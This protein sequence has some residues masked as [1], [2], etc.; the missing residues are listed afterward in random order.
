M[1]ATSNPAQ[2][3]ERH[4]SPRELAELWHLSA[5]HIRAL[6]LREP[7]VLIT[8]SRKYRTMRIPE[9]VAVRVHARSNSVSPAKPIR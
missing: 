6:F 5:D 8:G 4:F 9:S 2:V 7:G 3:F 1:E